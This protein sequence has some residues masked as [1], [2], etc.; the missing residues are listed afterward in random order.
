MLNFQLTR[1]KFYRKSLFASTILAATIFAVPALAHK[2]FLWPAK[3]M[4]QSGDTVEIALTSALTFPK[5]EFGPAKDRIAF[6][7]IVMAQHKVDAF[8]LEENKTNLNMTFLAD[9][10]GFGVISMSSKT[11]SGEI[12][13]EDTDGYLDEIGANETVREAFNNLPGT[14]VLHRSYNKH[15]KTFIC[16]ETCGEGAD[17]KYEPVGQKLEF[18][19]AKSGSRDFMLLL[20]GEPLTGQDVVVYGVDNKSRKYVTDKDGVVKV[21]RH[22]DGIAMLTAVWITMPTSPEGVYHS[23]YAALTLKLSNS[24]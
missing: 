4:W 20:D 8:T 24:H 12:K 6:S 1:I 10:V 22:H 9:R 21:L 2:T 7:S 11:R 15:T 14:P 3:F 5:L 18:I 17:K 19:A 16:V 13:P 23:D